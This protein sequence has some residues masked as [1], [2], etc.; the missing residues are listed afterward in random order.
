MSR[1]GIRKMNKLRE[2]MA[3]GRAVCQRDRVLKA[4]GDPEHLPGRE[5]WPEWAWVGAGV[6]MRRRLV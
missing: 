6:C 5:A 4:Q 2:W 3:E 1:L